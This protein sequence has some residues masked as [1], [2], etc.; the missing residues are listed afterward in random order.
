VVAS[1]LRDDPTPPSRVVESLPGD[2][3]SIVSRALAKEPTERYA[4]VHDIVRD[5]K[6]LLGVDDPEPYL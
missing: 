3:D 2:I 5:L 6:Q 1:I 4:N